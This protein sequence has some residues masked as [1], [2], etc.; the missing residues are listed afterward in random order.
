MRNRKAA[1]G[2]GLEAEFW[3]EILL[4]L[5]GYRIRARRYRGGGAEIDLIAARGSTLVVVEVKARESLDSALETISP[6]KVAQLARGT[7][8]FLAG[9]GRMPA[10][11]RCDAVLVAPGR[12]P[13]HIVSVAELPLD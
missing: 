8:A 5:K 2:L 3:A 11:I 6:A 9:L 4:R 7:R 1:Y 10:T 13:R 12:L